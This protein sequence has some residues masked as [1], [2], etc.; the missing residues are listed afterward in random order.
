MN[1]LRR[2]VLSN[3][4]FLLI[5]AALFC[6]SQ[7][8]HA[9]ENAFARI[10]S[11]GKIIVGM[12]GE[13][14]PFNFVTNENNIIGYDVELADLLAS[15]IPAQVEIALMPFAELIKALEDNKIDVIISGFSFSKERSAKSTLI[16]P[17]AIT[18]KSLLVTKDNLQRIRNSTGFNDKNVRILAMKKS[19]SL[20]LAKERLPDAQI[21]TVDHYE[22]A[23]LALH[24]N[25]ADALMTDLTICNLAV[26]RDTTSKLTHLEKPLAI[27]EIVIAVNREEIQLQS[28]LREKLITLT[29]NGELQKLQERW[30]KNPG[31]LEYLP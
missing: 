26:L 22:D 11:S 19:T 25:K 13:Q 8:V 1:V 16:G 3:H 4:F 23:I 18:G 28:K 24:A 31:W 10:K 30:F 2:R 5:A 15:A 14:P 6:C 7:I 20:A 17:Y 27:E 21:D 12:S 9:E 29:S